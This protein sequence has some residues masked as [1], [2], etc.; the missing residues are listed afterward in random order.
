MCE[1]CQISVPLDLDIIAWKTRY[2]AMFDDE[3]AEF[4]L[5]PESEDERRAIIAATF[6]QLIALQQ[7]R[8]QYV[9]DRFGKT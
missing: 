7:K 9:Y 1:Y 5:K 4:K 8:R 2:L 6:D 3:I